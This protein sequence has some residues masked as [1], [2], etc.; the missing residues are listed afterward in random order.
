MRAEA[1]LMVDGG[2]TVESF[3]VRPE[4]GPAE[5]N[6]QRRIGLLNAVARSRANGVGALEHLVGEIYDHRW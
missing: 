6:D 2:Q 5:K 3:F 4:G 1:A